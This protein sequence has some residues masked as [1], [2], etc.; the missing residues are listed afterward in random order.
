MSDL[1]GN[2]ED[3]FSHIAAHI[4]ISILSAVNTAQPRDLTPTLKQILVYT[5]DKQ[6]LF[7]CSRNSLNAALFAIFFLESRIKYQ[8]RIQSLL[9]LLFCWELRQMIQGFFKTGP[10][11]YKYR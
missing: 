2:P 1:I 11:K 8:I 4:A 9:P 10:E 7:S 3:R 6:D 5:Q